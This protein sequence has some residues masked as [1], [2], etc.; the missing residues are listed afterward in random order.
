MV[1][2]SLAAV[3]FNQKCALEHATVPPVHGISKQSVWLTHAI[4][5]KLALSQQQEQLQI[6]KIDAAYLWKLATYPVQV[7]NRS[8]GGTTTVMSRLVA[9]THTPAVVVMPTC[10]GHIMNALNIVEA[11]HALIL[12]RPLKYAQM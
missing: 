10:L 5:A 9:D 7:E 1:Q 3:V 8:T 6:V 12:H 2:Q 4:I 11:Q